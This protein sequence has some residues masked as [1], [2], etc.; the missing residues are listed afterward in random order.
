MV[1]AGVGTA[2]KKIATYERAKTI[3]D[4]AHGEGRHMSTVCCLAG[5][6]SRYIAD[7]PERALEYG[8]QALAVAEGAGKGEGIE[9]E[10]ALYMIGYAHQRL[11]RWD[12]ALEHYERRER[13]L[14]A[15]Y[16][17]EGAK[18]QA[19][20]AEAYKQI[21]EVHYAGR[22]DSERAL[23]Y[24]MKAVPVAEMA[25]GRLSGTTGNLCHS[26]GVAYTD[27]EYGRRDSPPQ[28]AEAVPWFERAVAAFAF[29]YENSEEPS[30]HCKRA[31]RN[32]ENARRGA[33]RQK[34]EALRLRKGRDTVLA[35]GVSL[36][37]CYNG[38]VR[39]LT[40]SCDV[41]CEACGGRGGEAGCE[42][43]TCTGCDGHGVVI[44]IR[45]LAPGMKQQVQC[46]CDDCGGKGKVMDPVK[47]C[48]ECE[49]EKVKKEP[50]VFE[51]AIDRGSRNN[52]KI[53]FNGESDQA[54]GVDPGDI[55]FVIKVEDDPKFTRKGHHLFMRKKVKVST[56]EALTGIS[57]TVEHLD[58]RTL[59]VSTEPGSVI[60]DGSAKMIE[61]E[62]MP[63][64]GNPSVKGNLVIHF[65]IDDS[66]ELDPKVVKQLESA[67]SGREGG[68]DMV[69]CLL[70]PFDAPAAEA[71]YE[72]NK[73][74]S[75]SDGDSDGDFDG[76]S[77]DSGAQCAQ[78]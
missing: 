7:D 38:K 34:K 66:A 23:E 4:R 5:I 25:T 72:Q 6:A 3:W 12:E 73:S 28:Y 42:M 63:M 22:G 18:K 39:T 20:V 69:P 62:G 65:E 2:E 44:Q 74:A 54:P 30:S 11:E 17:E 24:F 1:M 21:G 37:D 27:A 64:H 10:G 29:T 70:R 13:V 41:L 55:I 36:A 16:G 47:R 50:K 40:V 32:L 58:G 67:A 77:D 15:H 59:H 43:V 26:I 33:A 49:G 31:E 68:G 51:V 71:E 45:Q 8:M 75:D 76:D 56:Q 19:K 46:T 52:Q 60:A 35:L 53:R 57:F 48:K 9:A 14:L 61:Q 78:S